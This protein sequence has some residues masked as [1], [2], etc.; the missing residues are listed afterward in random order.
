MVLNNN[1]LDKWFKEDSVYFH[2]H[3]FKQQVKFYT[4]ND[5]LVMIKRFMK[6]LR[7]EEYYYNKDGLRNKLAEIYFSR[8]KNTLGNKLGFYIQPNCLGLGTTI[9]HHGTIII[10]GDAKL[11]DYCK[12]HG[13]NCVGNDGFSLKAPCIGNNVDIGFGAIIIGD[14]K[15]ADNVKIGAGAVVTTSCLHEGATLVGIPAHEL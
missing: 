4:V 6:Y 14:I 13:N 12:L 1:E 9:Y 2:S 3:T 11:G 15:I 10:N 5:H 7:K 8:K